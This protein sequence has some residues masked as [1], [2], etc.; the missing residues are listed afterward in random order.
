MLPFWFYHAKEISK[1]Q[2]NDQTTQEIFL[3]AS[4]DHLFW[5]VKYTI[6]KISDTNHQISYTSDILDYLEFPST[7]I[8]K[9]PGT[10]INTGI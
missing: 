3:S 1:F 2:S 8:F 5:S 9:F 4:Y 7:A 6:M 10:W